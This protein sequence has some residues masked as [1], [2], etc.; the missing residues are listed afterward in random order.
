MK[1]L[2]LILLVPSLAF[3]EDQKK[4]EDATCTE[5]KASLFDIQQ[6]QTELQKKAEAI[7]EEGKKKCAPPKESKKKKDE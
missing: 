7:V 1:Y 2:A 3:A 5:I 4:L 6:A